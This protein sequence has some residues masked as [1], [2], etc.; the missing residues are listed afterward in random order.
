MPRRRCSSEAFAPHAARLAFSRADGCLAASDSAGCG[1]DSPGPDA[2]G[3]DGVRR[4]GARTVHW[5]RELCDALFQ[6]SGWIEDVG[7]DRLGAARS[8]AAKIRCLASVVLALAGRWPAGA[9]ASAV[10]LGG[11]CLSAETSGEFARVCHRV[12]HVMVM[13]RTLLQDA[14]ASW[15]EALMPAP[16]AGRPQAGI[17]FHRAQAPAGRR[18]ASA[19]GLGHTLDL[20]VMLRH[21]A[22]ADARLRT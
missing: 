13:L 19:G 12:K 20:R 16:G 10:S 18:S 11:S 3:W 7:K 4:W 1:L 14:P 9:L 8:G 2:S 22:A 5:G 21:P 15:L 6:K 17:C